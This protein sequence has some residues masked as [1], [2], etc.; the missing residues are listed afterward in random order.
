MSPTSYQA[1]PPR[2]LTIA[3]GEVSVK[4]TALRLLVRL[5]LYGI[6]LRQAF[7]DARF[8]C[9]DTRLTTVAADLTEAG[10]QVV[11]ELPS[12]LVCSQLECTSSMPVPVWSGESTV[13]L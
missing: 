1:A 5:H 2:N 7:G 13:S 11:Y 4:P 8:L 3:N 12:L 6:G 10:Y 9:T